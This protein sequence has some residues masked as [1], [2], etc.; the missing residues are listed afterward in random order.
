MSDGEP[1]ITVRKMAAWAAIP[2]ELLEDREIVSAP[3][4][5]RFRFRWWRE[6]QREKLARVAYRAVAGDWPHNPDE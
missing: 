3:M 6:R 1:E 2:R 4:P 5:W